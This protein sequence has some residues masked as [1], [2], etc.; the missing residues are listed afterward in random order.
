MMNKLIFGLSDVFSNS[1]EGDYSNINQASLL[2]QI[3]TNRITGISYK[4]MYKCTVNWKKECKDVLETMYKN[5]V[6]KSRIYKSFVKE[7]AGILEKAQF[8]YA[9]LKGAYL[10]T[11]LYEEGMRTS[12]DIDILIQEKDIE[13]CQKLLKTNGFIQGYVEKGKNIRK[14]SRREIVMSRM[15]YGETVPFVKIVNGEVLE[16]DINFSLDYKPERELNKVRCLLERRELVKFENISYYTLNQYDFFIHLSCHL[17]KEATTLNWINDGSDLLLYKFSDINIFLFKVL[18]ALNV[19]V[20]LSRIKEHQVEKE[21]YYTLVNTAKIYPQIKKLSVYS[22]LVENIKI[23]NTDFMKQIIDPIT[24]KKYYY[25]MSFED[26]FFTEDK[27]KV[28][29]QTI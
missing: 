5:N 21:C 22:I 26:W 25:E 3:C 16:I 9:L 6:Q 27:I 18:P 1:I 23:E 24:E 15:N 13:E 29:K 8:R 20:L 12:N 4:N 10:S 7:I 11:V 28:L 17:Y 2:G 14:A 19:N